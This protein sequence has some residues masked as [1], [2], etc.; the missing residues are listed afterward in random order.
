MDSREIA[1]TVG[2]ED[3]SALCHAAEA[4][5]MSIEA[6]VSWGVRILAMQARPGGTGRREPSAGPPPQRR[7][8][9]GVEESEAAAWAETFTQ[10][11]S[12]RAARLHETEI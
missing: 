9:A 8:D 5:G 10:R 3:W 7:E 1:V 12:H 4:A 2:E 6:Y 11:L